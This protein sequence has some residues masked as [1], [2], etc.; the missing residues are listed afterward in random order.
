MSA[1]DQVIYL[2]HGGHRRRYVV[3]APAGADPEVAKPAVFMLDGRG[4]TP[5]TAMK[6]TGWSALADRAGFHAIY[7]E[8]LRVNPAGPQH[9]LDNPQI[10]HLDRD[11]VD[12][13]GFLSDVLQDVPTHF[14]IDPRRLYCA[15]FSNGAAMTFRFAAEFPERVAA[16]G[17]VAGHHLDDAPP[18][19]R[20]VPLCYLFGGRDPISPFDGGPVTLPWGQSED[21]PPVR[22]T[23][24]HWARR[25]GAPEFA[26]AVEEQPGLRVE[27]YGA[28]LVMYVVE[29][30]GHVWPGGHRLLPERL[31]GSG[32]DRLNATEVL[33]AF[34]RDCA[35][36]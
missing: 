12:D 31:V 13:I 25:C 33:W 34:F 10:W 32:S 21:R 15:G 20:P 3:H 22:D 16:I 1:G 24:R 23:I 17:P 30:L 9:F 4:G 29:D 35:L 36:E 5:W 26:S 18:L 8:A 2:N 19:S 6:S 27:R 7:P 14:P 28:D 11:E